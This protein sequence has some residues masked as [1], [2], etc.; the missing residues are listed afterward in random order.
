MKGKQRHHTGSRVLLVR[1]LVE[2]K[3]FRFLEILS[4]DEMVSREE[5]WLAESLAFSKV[6]GTF[7]TRRAM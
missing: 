5:R 4:E 7:R 6:Q 3:N 2:R 1:F